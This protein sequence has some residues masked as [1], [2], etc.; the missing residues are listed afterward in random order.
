MNEE[1]WKDIKFFDNKNNVEW[2]FTGLYQVSNCGRVKSLIGKEKILSPTVRKEG[3]KYV[4]L[5]L[6]GGQDKMFYIHRL[7]GFMFVENDNPDTKICINHK[8]E[9]PS[10]NFYEN[11]EWC[12]YSE[13][14]NYGGRNERVAQ[15]MR[16]KGSCERCNGFK[17]THI[18]TGEVIVFNRIR[19][20][21]EKGY[22]SM[23]IYNCCSGKCKSYMGYTWEKIFD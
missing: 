9:N 12:T 6:G 23:M 7:V 19:E 11:L 5:S 1:I 17:A 4:K 3:Y 2:D 21:K 10:N 22:S 15:T 20:A 8:D 16:K 18:E 14:I 13:N